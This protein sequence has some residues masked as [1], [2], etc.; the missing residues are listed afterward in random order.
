MN[1]YPYVYKITNLLTGQFYIG[2]RFA[3]VKM[4]RYAVDDLKHYYCS[5]SHKVKQEIKTVGIENFQFDVLFQFDS[6]T[7]CFVYENLLIKNNTSNPLIINKWYLDPDKDSKVF[8]KDTEDTRLKKSRAKKGKPSNA[9]GYVQTKEDLA[10]ANLSRKRR[11]ESMTEEKK[12][13]IRDA[14]SQGNKGKPK[15]YTTC[16]AKKF[17]CRLSDRKEFSKASAGKY[18]KEIMQFF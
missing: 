18:L 15:L 6:Y 3:N 16:C 17:V 12:Q 14:I 13:Y 11:R 10:K 7:V 5:S 1:I 8:Y 9:H 2:S 4:N